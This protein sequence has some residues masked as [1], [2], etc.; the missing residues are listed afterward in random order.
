MKTVLKA[1]L[2]FTWK[3]FAEKQYCSTNIKQLFWRIE[4]VCFVVTTVQIEY[5]CHTDTD[6]LEL[7]SNQYVTKHHQRLKIISHFAP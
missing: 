1:T 2:Y 6:K 7:L 4:S 5:F 3:D